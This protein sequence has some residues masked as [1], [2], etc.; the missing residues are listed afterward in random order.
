MKTYRPQ[1]KNV[2]NVLYMSPTRC[3]TRAVFGIECKLRL[4]IHLMHLD[5]LRRKNKTCA[6]SITKNVL[7]N[8]YEDA[9][10]QHKW[11][12]TKEFPKKNQATSGSL[13]KD[14][15]GALRKC[16]STWECSNN[17]LQISIEEGRDEPS[18]WKPQEKR[19]GK[20]IVRKGATEIKSVQ[21]WTD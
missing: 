17:E 11:G 20:N 10:C 1:R 18:T 19:Q 9:N 3:Q 12:P 8:I 13:K 15:G 2:F 7:R 21:N 14:H 5:T 16:I 4:Y 6:P